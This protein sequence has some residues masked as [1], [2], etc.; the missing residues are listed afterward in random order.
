M[1]KWKTQ[2]ISRLSSA[3]LIAGSYIERSYDSMFFIERLV[4]SR[5]ITVGVARA[6]ACGREPRH[7]EKYSNVQIGEEQSTMKR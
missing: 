3:C 1:E 2:M 4:F 6:E 7:V 5:G